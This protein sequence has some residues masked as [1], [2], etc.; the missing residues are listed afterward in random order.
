MM[1]LHSLC[2]CYDSWIHAFIYTASLQLFVD[3][4]TNVDVTV[5]RIIE[6]M[7]L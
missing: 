6:K 4:C 2:N 5:I 3:V 7:S 1:S